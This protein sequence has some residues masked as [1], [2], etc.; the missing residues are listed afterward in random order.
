MPRNI[1]PVDQI[2]RA[3]LGLA[4]AYFRKD[5]LYAEGLDLTGRAA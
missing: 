2:V 5:R 1:R 4:I 3:M